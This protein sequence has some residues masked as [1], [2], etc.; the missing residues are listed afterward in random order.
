[1]HHPIQF[2]ELQ[3]LSGPAKQSKSRES[4]SAGAAAAGT[5]T[6]TGC[7]EK[8]RKYGKGS[9]EHKSLTEAVTRCIVTDMFPISIVDND[10]F[11]ELVSKLNPRYDMPHK[12]HFSKLAIPSLYEITKE[13][14]QHKI[15]NEMG[16][17]FCHSIFVVIMHQ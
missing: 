14:I 3:A 16:N 10:G 5:S 9:R 15:T 11:H 4:K 13:D 1:M 17:F 7:F 12:D 8:D 6:I 2:N